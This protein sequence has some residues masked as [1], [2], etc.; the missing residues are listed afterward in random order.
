[1]KFF[2]QIIYTTVIYSAKNFDV[3]KFHGLIWYFVERLRDLKEKSTT[4]VPRT[5]TIA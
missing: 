5:P 4:A 2:G 1:M 3:L